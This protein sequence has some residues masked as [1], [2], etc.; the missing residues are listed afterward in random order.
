[1]LGNFRT[2]GKIIDLLQNILVHILSFVNTS[3][4]CKAPNSK[5]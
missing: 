1:M 4:T 2:N 5:N 3:W